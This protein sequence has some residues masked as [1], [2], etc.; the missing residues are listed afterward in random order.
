MSFGPPHAFT[1]DLHPP[2]SFW[3]T[4]AP[5]KAP[6]ANTATCDGDR[7]PYAATATKGSDGTPEHIL[8]ALPVHREAGSGRAKGSAVANTV[9]S[10]LRRVEVSHRHR[11]KPRSA[12]ATADRDGGIKLDDGGLGSVELRGGSKSSAAGG[13]RRRQR[14]R[15]CSGGSPC[16]EGTARSFLD[17]AGGATAVD[18]SGDGVEDSGGGRFSPKTAMPPPAAR[19]CW[20]N[21]GR[22]DGG[23]DGG[24][25]DGD[26]GGDDDGGD[27]QFQSYYLAGASRSSSRGS[28]RGRTDRER[29]SSSN[30]SPTRILSWAPLGSETDAREA[31]EEWPVSPGLRKGA[32]QAGGDLFDKVSPPRSSAG[33][34]RRSKGIGV[35]VGIGDPATGLAF[36][37]IQRDLLT[38]LEKLFVTIADERRK[39]LVALKREEEIWKASAIERAKRD[40]RTASA[41]RNDGDDNG[42]NSNSNSS[43]SATAHPS[44]GRS[45]EERVRERV[46][47]EGPGPEALA[48]VGLVRDRDEAFQLS[49]EGDGIGKG[50][51][52]WRLPHKV[53]EEMRQDFR[54]KLDEEC[55]Q[56]LEQENKALLE[57]R[58]GLA[59]REGARTE[60]EL[61]EL[62]DRLTNDGRDALACL[63]RQ[64]EKK[65][66]NASPLRGKT[67]KKLWPIRCSRSESG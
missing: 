14:R 17:G 44:F 64:L 58:A 10:A 52:G 21:D 30:E 59:E 45:L 12:A 37:Q 61:R 38:Q 8:D 5:K 3:S 18:K 7:A 43:N 11:R 35:G 1:T 39:G 65:K 4:S 34:P 54:R 15:G 24:G 31:K 62:S 53:V 46:V 33:S 41:G 25:D 32:E 13:Q 57:A 6:V 60:R 19:E 36:V 63:Q 23:G 47:E 49:G 51:G 27:Q 40:L 48:A 66:K 9:C 16:N 20:G 56:V 2:P 28:R 29:G 26:D 22:D 55:N 67:S 42:S 50:R